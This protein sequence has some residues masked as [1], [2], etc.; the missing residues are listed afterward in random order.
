MLGVIGGVGAGLALGDS[1]ARAEEGPHAGHGHGAHGQATK[2]D[3]MMAPVAAV[4]AHFCGIH[5]AKNNPKFQLVAQH[6]CSARSDAEHKID[7]H[8][9]LLYD[10]YDKNAKLLGV[11]YIVSNDVYQRLPS[12]E[13]KYWHPHTYEVLA[14]GLIAPGMKPEDEL[15]FM[16]AILTTWGKT[17]HTWPD[18][19]T[20][21]PMGEPLLVWSLTGDSQDD[22]EV[23]AARD[24]Q[25]GVATAEIRER[26]GKA[27]G[28]EVPQVS[29][30]KSM[31]AIGRQWTDEGDDKPTRKP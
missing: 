13:K 20:P 11:E 28:L 21:V 23:V 26:R 27:F 5:V 22:K 7:M 29:P 9:C 10:S 12:D 15:R 1:A 31:D 17:W 14:G 4:H 2:A 24:R 3:S 6:Y 18:P 25:F 19:K 16:R 8:Q 30:P